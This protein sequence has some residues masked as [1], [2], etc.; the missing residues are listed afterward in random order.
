MAQ[1]IYTIKTLNFSCIKKAIVSWTKNI[2]CILNFLFLKKKQNKTRALQTSAVNTEVA[3]NING[4]CIRKKTR[5]QP[6]RLHSYGLDTACFQQQE[7][8][9]LFKHKIH[10]TQSTCL[11][12]CDLCWKKALPEA[13]VLLCTVYIMFWTLQSIHPPGW[14]GLKRNTSNDSIICYN[15]TTVYP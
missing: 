9:F 7:D 1:L 3:I 12:V 6:H 14:Q 13:P 11:A 5:S 8:A 2:N 15:S 10:Y 4:T